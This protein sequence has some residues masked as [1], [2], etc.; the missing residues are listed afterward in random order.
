[1]EKILK[2]GILGAGHIAAKMA[3]TIRQMPQACNL[4][5][6]S[7]E[8]SRAE[9][10]ASEHGVSRS[11]GSYE[12]MLMDPDVDLVYVATPHS[13]HFG[14]AMMSVANGKPVLCEKAFTANAR[15]AEELLTFA[16]ERGVFVTEAIWTRYMPFSRT[17]RELIDSGIIGAPH[18]LSA[19]LAYP[20]QAKE[21]I[22]RPELCG[23]ALLD[24]GVYCINFARMCFGT[25]IVGISSQCELGETGVDMQETISL[26]YRDGRIA[27][28]QAS[29]RCA[30]DRR[31]MI[32]GDK[33]YIEIDN[34]NNPK[35]ATVHGAWQE[36][37][38]VHHAPEC[39]NGYEYE[40][41]ACKDALEQGLTESPFMPHHEI[42]DIMRLMDSLRHE[43]G[44]I[45]PM[46]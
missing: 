17:I 41:L 11:Y 9:A 43:W 33:G 27:N 21:R 45:Y 46:D 24:L 14:H 8:L 12:E 40:V 2:V 3:E 29:A 42:L 39:I 38:E 6:A 23:G 5:V 44:V 20:I 4:A 10:F 37:L 34:V 22:L 32:Y 31:G 7:R 25:D 36:T 15:E 16:R 28:L 30:N 19:S 26:K 18:L 13:H 1:M 35:T